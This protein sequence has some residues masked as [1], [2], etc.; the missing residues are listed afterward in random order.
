MTC[1]SVGYGDTNPWW[2]VDLQDVYRIS[3]VEIVGRSDCCADRL[4][5]FTIDVYVD[6]PA[7]TV[8]AQPTLCH[9]YHGVFRPT[10]QDIMCDSV[11]AGR[12]VR[13]SGKKTPPAGDLFTLCE[14]SIYE[15]E[16]YAAHFRNTNVSLTGL[17][18]AALPLDLLSCVVNCVTDPLCIAVKMVRHETRGCQLIHRHVDPA[19]TTRLTL[20]NC[21]VPT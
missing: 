11:V 20:S 17:T 12:F 8:S 13:L 5:D 9:Y 1:H 16:K 10:T 4:H 7:V 15:P 19:R 3:R 18:V 21:F 2:Q 14:V 6:D